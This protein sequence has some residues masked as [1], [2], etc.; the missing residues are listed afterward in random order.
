MASIMD[1]QSIKHKKNEKCLLITGRYLFYK[2][3]EA[4]LKL[5]EI[6]LNILLI[7]ISTWLYAFT[8]ICLCKLQ[9]VKIM[10]EGENLMQ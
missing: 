7:S 3:T 5:E 10:T 6:N 2:N 4:A 9:T 1:Q 8:V